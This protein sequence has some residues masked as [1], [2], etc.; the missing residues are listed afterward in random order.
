MHHLI[1]QNANYSLSHRG[2]NNCR[3]IKECASNLMIHIHALIYHNCIGLLIWT[4][5]VII[6]KAVNCL[7]LLLLQLFIRLFEFNTFDFANF[8][9]YSFSTFIFHI[10][11]IK[12]VCFWAKESPCNYKFFYVGCSNGSIRFCDNRLKF[13]KS[14]KIS[15]IWS[16]LTT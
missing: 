8:F 6:D 9:E 12:L 5:L 13:I 11:T 10:K 1:Y 16:S 4:S 2:C 7:E 3:S 15:N 14:F